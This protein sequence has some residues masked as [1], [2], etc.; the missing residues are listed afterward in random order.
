[1]PLLKTLLALAFVIMG[2]VF[3]ALNRDVMH[4]DLFFTTLQASIGLTVLLVLL[5]GCLLGGLVVLA[6]VVW[7]MRSN[8]IKAEKAAAKIVVE[9]NSSP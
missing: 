4:I 1:M 2:I 3:G 9:G 6:T 7:P 5:L 8:L